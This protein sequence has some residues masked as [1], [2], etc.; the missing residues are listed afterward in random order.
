MLTGAGVSTDSGIPDYRGPVSRLRVRTPIQHHAFVSQPSTRQRYWARSSVGW[1]RFS[2]AKPNVAHHTLAQMER[3][4]LVTGLITQNVDELHSKAG[5]QAVVDL[6]G[7]LSRVRCLACHSVENREALQHRL[8]LLNP[9]WIDTSAELAPDGDADMPSGLIETF[10]VPA[11]LQCDG[12]LKPDVVFFGGNVPADLVRN[13]YQMVNDAQALL[14]LGSSL[15]VF[16]GLRFVRRAKERD[17]PIVIVNM[18]ETR[19]DQDATLTCHAPVSDV[20]SRLIERL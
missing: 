7:V 17:I 1:P 18:G 16:S 8:M 12:I 9:S 20:L 15:T 11:C 13:A 6:H 14:V 3:S 4:A 10:R 5:Q 2:L 19:G